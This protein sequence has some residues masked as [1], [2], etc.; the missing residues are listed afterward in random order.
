MRKALQGP[1]VRY[2][3]IE[4][5]ALD[6]IN[7]ARRLRHY[8]LAHTIIVQIDQPVRKLL[9][10]PDMACRILKW[11]FELSEFDIQYEIKKALKDQALADFIAE[12]TT[13]NPPQGRSTSV[14]S[15]WMKIPARRGVE[16]ESSSKIRQ[17]S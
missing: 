12:M 1:E 10:R 14:P 13:C 16:Q 17:A 3:Q 8:F 5:V 15:F 6:L 7:M 4:K 2:Q 9:G 11:S